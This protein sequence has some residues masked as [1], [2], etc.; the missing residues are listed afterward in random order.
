MLAY[1]FGAGEGSEAVRGSHEP[2][3]TWLHGPC[4]WSR[5]WSLVSCLASGIGLDED[6]VVGFCSRSSYWCSSPSPVLRCPTC[7]L[8]AQEAR[9]PPQLA[10]VA[11]I[12][13]MSE[14]ALPAR[15]S[16]RERS[17]GQSLPEDD[18]PESVPPKWCPLGLSPPLHGH[19]PPAASDACRSQP[20]G[21]LPAITLVLDVFSFGNTTSSGS[22][23]GAACARPS[24]LREA[25]VDRRSEQPPENAHG[26]YGVGL[27]P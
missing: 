1:Y 20:R 24:Q 22:A 17:R 11:E 16:S 21:G 8:W 14:R 18:P 4:G 25:S 13:G 23:S 2:K 3:E 27:A 7:W 6:F 15:A 12:R 26:T 19:T 10:G 9:A 5:R